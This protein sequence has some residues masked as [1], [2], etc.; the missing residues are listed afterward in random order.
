MGERVRSKAHSPTRRVYHP[1]KR[2]DE[3][4][5]TSEVSYDFVMAIRKI[6]I[7]L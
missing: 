6:A 4:F 5:S 3:R 7:Y 1:S 2:V